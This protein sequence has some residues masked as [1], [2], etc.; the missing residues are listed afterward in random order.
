MTQPKILA[1]AGSARSASFNKLLVR[2][3]ADHARSAGAQV[4]LIDLREFPMPLYDGDT[5]AASGIPAQALRFRALLAENQGFLIAS[6]EHNGSVSALLK[7]ALDWSSRPSAGEDGLALVRGKTF[8]LLS[9]SL[10]PYGGVRGAAHLRGILS[11][12]GAN[13]LA[14]EV[15]VADAGNAFD[16]QGQLRN[17][18]SIKLT[19]QL[20]ANLASQIRRLGT[21]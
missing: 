5:E 10:G 6:P 18:L 8:A 12:M 9:A 17:E 19:A 21:T 2:I 15:L 1:F 7:N 20:A 4:T 11:K 3:A 13:V 16:A 14:D